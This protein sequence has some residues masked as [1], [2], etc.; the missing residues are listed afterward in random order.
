M[1]EVQL[2]K[3]NWDK[4]GN[5]WDVA[6]VSRELRIAHAKKNGGNLYANPGEYCI[7]VGGALNWKYRQL[8]PLMAQ[9]L[10]YELTSNLEK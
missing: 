10:L 5:T 4:T 8:D 7:D 9:A 1:T 3:L 6:V 2:D